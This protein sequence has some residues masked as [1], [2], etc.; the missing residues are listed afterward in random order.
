MTA[1]SRKRVVVLISG[2]GSNMEALAEAAADPA[3]PAEI[4]GVLSDKAEAGGLAVA[5]GRGIEAIAVPRKGL[6][7]KAAHEAAICAEIDRLGGEIICLAGFM[8]LLSPEFIRR[9]RGRIINIHPSLLPLFPG[10]DTHERA[11][12]A[13]MRVHGCTVHFV[14]EGMDEGP[15]IAQAAVPLLPTDDT[16]RLAARVLVAE[17]RLYP[18]A[19]AMLADG[20]V[21]MDEAG[22]TAFAANFASSEDATPLI[23][24][25]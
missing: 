19:L 3:F 5:R 17:H 14:T 21:R 11:I 22:R 6:A 2:R 13:G 20:K 10:L 9:Y 4:V 16:A 12:E 25:G 23:S 8:R 7:D 15:I 18:A 1:S 24:A